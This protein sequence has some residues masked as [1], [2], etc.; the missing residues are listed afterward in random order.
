MK[1]GT[2]LLIF[3]SIFL[4]LIPWFGFHFI[5]RI[6]RSLLQ[7]QEEAQ[8]MAASAIATVLNGYTELFDIDEDALYIYPVKQDIDVDGY[9]EDW[10]ELSDQFTSYADN[11]FSLLLVEQGQYLYAYL[12]VYDSNIVYRNPRNIALDTSDHIRLEYLDGKNVAHRL[13]L[14]AEGQGNVSVYEVNEDWQTWVNG[15]H[16]NA[17]YGVWHETATG[18]DVEFRL[19]REWL[20][21][22]RRLS[23]SVVNMFSENERNID[24]IVSTH[25]MNK[26]RLNPLLFQSQKINSV[27]ENLGKSDSRICVIDKYRRV[28]AVMGGQRLHASLCQSI[29]KVS[30]TMVNRV[31]LG[32]SQVTRFDDDSETLI[33]AAHPVFAADEIIGAVLVSKNSQQILSL[34][35]ETLQ[36]II[37]VI[38]GLFVLV[39]V[40]L[41]SF[42]SWLTFR[43]NRLTNQTSSLIDES[44]R[45]IRQVDLPDTR[46]G[47]EIGELARS[48]S[49]LLDRLNRYTCF[50]E[51][52]PRMLRHEILNPVNTISMSLQNIAAAG[53]SGCE[54]G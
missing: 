23:L 19:P 11:A 33:V 4:V 8:S 6:E 39:F 24:T 30:E 31:L 49:S 35:R 25:T 7:A 43:I 32:D 18:Y 9:D 53:R 40:S 21:P 52:V 38:A 42:S 1:L 20:E 50:L 36:D 54:S 17:V 3:S 44:G 37:F 16:I 47:D 13:V 41:L 48:F 2:R 45:F 28:R 5:E 27:I 51:T 22:N 29:D 12:K 26:N 14:L 34:Q 46:H 15:R 10:D